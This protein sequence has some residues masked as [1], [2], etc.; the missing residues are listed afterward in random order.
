MLVDDEL[1]GFSAI[2]LFAG[3]GGTALGLSNAGFDHLLLS[4]IDKYAASTLRA[5]KPDWNVIEGDV[6]GLDFQNITEKSI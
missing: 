2:D 1:N 4:E 6:A 3:A 5:N